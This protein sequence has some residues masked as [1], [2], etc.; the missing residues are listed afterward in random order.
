[1]TA[2]IVCLNALVHAQVI[3]ENAQAPLAREN[4]PQGP[5]VPEQACAERPLTR[6]Q[7]LGAP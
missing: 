1:M 6:F 3:Q 7:A 5:E 2:S 4:R